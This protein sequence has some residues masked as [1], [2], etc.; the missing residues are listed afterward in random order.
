MKRVMELIGV[1]LGIVCLYVKMLLMLNLILYIVFIIYKKII[2][3]LFLYVL[4]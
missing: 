2:E 3:N 1:K 4:K